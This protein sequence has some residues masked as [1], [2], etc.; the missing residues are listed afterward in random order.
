[1]HSRNQN[2]TRLNALTCVVTHLDLLAIDH[3]L[4]E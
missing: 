2:P 4:T 3:L 1:M